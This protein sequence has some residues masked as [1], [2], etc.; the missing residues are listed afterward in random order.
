[1]AAR[2]GR[3]SGSS[4]IDGPVMRDLTERRRRNEDVTGREGKARNRQERQGTGTPRQERA[5]RGP[6]PRPSVVHV[7]RYIAR[8]LLYSVLVLVIISIL[9]FLIFVK[10]PAGDPARRAV[11]RRTDP[12]QIANAREPSAW[13]G[14]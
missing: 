7:L 12:Q 2:P 4:T 1:M 9:T 11:G 8:R 3:S 10:L 14:R 6:S 5:I 13:T